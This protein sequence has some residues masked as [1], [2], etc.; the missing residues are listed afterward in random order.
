MKKPGRGHERM[1]DMYFFLYGIDLYLE[2]TVNM[3]EVRL[4]YWAL[5]K[6]SLK[7]SVSYNWVLLQKMSNETTYPQENRAFS[8]FNVIWTEIIKKWKLF[9]LEKAISQ[10]TITTFG[11][12]MLNT[13]RVPSNGF[14]I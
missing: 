13:Y 6:E 9:P 12:K 3:T 8:R 5:S 4:S 14:E 7:G 2:D 11:P 1:Y 10:V